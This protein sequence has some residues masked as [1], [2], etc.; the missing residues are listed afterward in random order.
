LRTIKHLLLVG[1]STLL[2]WAFAGRHA[3]ALISD[4]LCT[5]TH[6]ETEPAV[7]HDG[8]SIAFVRY[9]TSG[10]PWETPRSEIHVLSEGR[11]T[12]HVMTLDDRVRLLSWSP[13]G[14]RIAFSYGTS[15]EGVYVVNLDGDDL[16]WLNQEGGS[17]WAP[18]WSPDGM[19]IAFRHVTEGVQTM[20]VEEDGDIRTL[21]ADGDF[22]AWSPDG[23]KLAYTSTDFF[24][25]A[26]GL[27]V[28]DLVEGTHST[29]VSGQSF[30]FVERPSWSYDGK[31]LAFA[32]TARTNGGDR[33][34]RLEIYSIE[35][36]GSGFRR[37]TNNRVLDRSPAWTPDGRIVLE[38]ERS[39]RRELYV[40]NPD[41]TGAH[42]LLAH[43]PRDDCRWTPTTP[44]SPRRA[45]QPSLG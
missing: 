6:G 41:G 21:V 36:D 2:A 39:G 11:E 4:V 29:L 30:P 42:R 5:S 15:P 33:W 24:G 44:L 27:V 26:H 19:T 14:S 9:E 8:R 10:C 38:S 43:A 25:V 28:I 45:T 7:S 34:E 23:S 17:K 16:R 12:Q 18:S 31:R 22:P 3:G 1:V 35:V 20:D 40:T 37:L 32:A 13:D